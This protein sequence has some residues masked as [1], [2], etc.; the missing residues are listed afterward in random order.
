[1]EEKPTVLQFLKLCISSTLNNE[2]LEIGK[3]PKR[4]SIDEVVKELLHEAK[5]IEGLGEGAEPIQRVP[6]LD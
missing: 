2:R 3:K 4:R 1:M 6:W 5:I